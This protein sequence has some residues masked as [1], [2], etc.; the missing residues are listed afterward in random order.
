MIFFKQPKLRFLIVGLIFISTSALAQ[1]FKDSLRMNRQL[2]IYAENGQLDS[3]L[4]VLRRGANPNYTTPFSITPLM[5]A[6]EGGHVD[7]VKT[8]LHNGANPDKQPLDGFSSLMHACL[9]ADFECAYAL[10]R[11]GAKLD[12]KDN[13]GGAALHYATISGSIDLVD[14]LIYYKANVNIKANDG[15]TPLHIAMYVKDTAMADLLIYHGAN[16]NAVNKKGYTP[17]MLATQENNVGVVKYLLKK[18]ANPN[19]LNDTSYAALSYAIMYE[20]DTLVEILAKRSDRN[21]LGK[22]NNHNPVNLSKQINRSVYSKSLQAKGYETNWRPAFNNMLFKTG[23][24]FSS[25]D[26]YF[27]QEVAFWEY[28]YNTTIGFGVSGRAKRK[29]IIIEQ[30]NNELYQVYERRF[31]WDANIRKRFVLAHDDGSNDQFGLY[32]GASFQ[33]ATGKYV[34]LKQKFDQRFFISPTA[35]LYFVA[36]DTYASLA[37]RYTPYGYRDLPNHKIELSIGMMMISNS[38]PQKYYPTWI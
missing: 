15:N 30:A 22:K 13:Y 24:S 29:P 10:A 4:S 32:V 20:R 19:I 12:L 7:V 9:N 36:D 11:Y 18:G 23:I 3:V 26:L 37:Y 35:G 21:I 28:K 6:T 16:I 5:Y 14:M 33:F 27:R 1:P 34:G 31:Y 25:K 2:C 8:L 38:L 17:L